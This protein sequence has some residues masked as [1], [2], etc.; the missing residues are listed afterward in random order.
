[1]LVSTA[2]SLS[3]SLLLHAPSAVG[4]QALEKK[5][6]E[7]PSTGTLIV[8]ASVLLCPAVLFFVLLLHL[9]PC[10]SLSLLKNESA[11]LQTQEA[12]GP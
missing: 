1:M 3:H 10:T 6:A 7:I 4:S 12:F 8:S 2:L 9:P 11:T 5:Q